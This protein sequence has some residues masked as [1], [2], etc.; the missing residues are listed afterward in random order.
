MGICRRDFLRCLGAAA[1]L[2]LVAAVPI[3]PKLLVLVVLEQIKGDALDGILPQLG[4]NGFKK[5]L[6][7]SAHFP[8]CRHLAS[9]FT[10]S[11]LA[12]LATGAWPAQHGIVADS[13]FEGGVV[14]QA[15]S[16]ALLATTLTA[17][18]AAF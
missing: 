11:T 1:P 12:T 2:G 15:S 7:Q 10:G 18:I 17:Q 6:Y 8:D 16:E 5:L 13:W 9:T 4:P 3:R 14:T